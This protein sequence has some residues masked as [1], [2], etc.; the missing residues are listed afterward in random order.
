MSRFCFDYLKS[1]MDEVNHNFSVLC[2][3]SEPE[4]IDICKEF[5]F[6]FY[7]AE[8]NPL[9]AK[10]NKGIKHAL[11]FDWD[12]L[13]IMNS[14]TVIKS[15]LFH[16]YDPYLKSHHDFFGVN[17]VTFVN[18][19]TSEA[20][21]YVY[22]FSILGC[23]KMIRREVVEAM[24]GNL[25]RPELNKCLDDT[26]MDNVLHATKVGGKIVKYDGQLVYDIKSDIN[27]H[28]WEKFA[29]RGKKVE[30]ELCY[31]AA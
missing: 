29:E 8:N 4:Y 15:E 11:K 28:P 18:F 25:Y 24:A 13:M 9:G 12:Y 7:M 10:I 27:I 1:M 3:I 19:K 23:G 31:K 30:N 5:G 21:D 20:I 17:K 26:M 16:A 14:D 22:E 6:D 2:V